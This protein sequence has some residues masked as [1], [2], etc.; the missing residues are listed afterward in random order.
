MEIDR[1]LKKVSEGTTDFDSIFQKVHE[2][3]NGS[4]KEKYEGELKKV[5]KKL[6]R[7]RDQIKS[8]TA[9][10]DIKNKGPLVDSRKIIE[11]VRALLLKSP[12]CLHCINSQF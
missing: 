2:A 7:Y 8:W 4:Q 1:L 12:C 6:Q 5:I 11:A 3:T 10:N 9:S